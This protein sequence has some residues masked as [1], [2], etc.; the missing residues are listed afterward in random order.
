MGVWNITGARGG[1]ALK[2]DNGP[3]GG[4]GKKIVGA[5]DQCMVEERLMSLNR[6]RN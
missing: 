4:I 1:R 6:M 2:E 5:L 3:Q